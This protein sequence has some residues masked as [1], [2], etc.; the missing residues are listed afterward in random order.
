MA[1]NNEL[2]FKAGGTITPC[3]FVK[4]DTTA[5]EQVVVAAANTDVII[6]VAQEGM[7]RAPGLPGSDSTIAAESG[8]LV[9]VH[10]LGNDC[11]LECGGTVTRFDY[12][13]SDSVGRGVT[14]STGNIYG[15]QALQSGSTGSKIRVLVL[16]GT[17]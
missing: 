1:R 3:R 12:L 2:S 8:D 14:A 10:S 17:R 16:F 11:L 13:T 4:G 9:Q 7:K 6:G 15:A 5:D